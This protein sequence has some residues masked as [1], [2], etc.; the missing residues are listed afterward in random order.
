LYFLTES[1]HRQNELYN[2]KYSSTDYINPQ[3]LLIMQQRKKGKLIFEHK[4]PKNLYLN[5]LVNKTQQGILTYDEIYN[6]LMK[7]YYTCT[8]TED[9]DKSLPSIKM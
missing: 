3:A 1:Y 7:F 2:G 9:E 4:I 8:V 6:V 5:M